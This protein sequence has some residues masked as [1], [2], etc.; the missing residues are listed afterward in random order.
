MPVK[1]VRCHVHAQTFTQAHTHYWGGLYYIAG[2]VVSLHLTDATIAVEE[3]FY[4]FCQIR[5][6]KRT[7]F[8]SPSLYC[9]KS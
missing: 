8:P 3:M 6:K 1:R 9:L 4:Y 5:Q 7:I 2:I